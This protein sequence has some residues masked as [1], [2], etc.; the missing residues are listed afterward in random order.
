MPRGAPERLCESP[1]SSIVLSALSRWCC[2]VRVWVVKMRV[3][4][5]TQPRRRIMHSAHD[6]RARSYKNT[7]GRGGANAATLSDFGAHRAPR[8]VG[9]RRGQTALRAGDFR[10]GCPKVRA[11][12]AMRGRRPHSMKSRLRGGCCY[13]PNHPGRPPPP[14][15][16]FASTAYDRRSIGGSI[17]RSIAL[18]DPIM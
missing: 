9:G 5:L 10:T 14:S 6:S 11:W 13:F 1:S 8:E 3:R 17:D 16:S 12:L 18:G 7:F 2:C 4:K 15:P